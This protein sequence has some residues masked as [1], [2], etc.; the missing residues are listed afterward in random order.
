[1]DKYM[2]LQVFLGQNMLLQVDNEK[3]VFVEMNFPKS[4]IMT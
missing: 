2:L 4:L 3:V 1:M